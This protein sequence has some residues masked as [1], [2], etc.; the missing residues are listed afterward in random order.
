MK[1]LLIIVY[2]GTLCL[3]TNMHTQ[4]RTIQFEKEILPILQEKCWRCH[5]SRVKEPSAGLL[6]DTPK[7][8]MSGNEYGPVI[9]RMLPDESVLVERIEIKPGKRG[10][11]PPTGQGD[12][13]SPKQIALIR[14]WIKQG[15]KT[16][17]WQGYQKPKQAYQPKDQRYN[18]PLSHQQ[19]GKNDKNPGLKFI[20]MPE[21]NMRISHSLIRSKAQEIDQIIQKNRSKKGFK[22]PVK[23]ND[24]IFLRRAYLGIVG[25]IP[26]LNESVEFLASTQSNKRILLIDKLIASEGYASHWFHFWADLLKVDSTAVD[27]VAAVYYADWVK[28]ALASNMPYDQMV[29]ELITATGMPYQNGAT[30][31][32]ASDQNMKPDHMA[33]TVQAF[34]GIQIQCAQ[35]H[36]HPFDQWN[37]FEFQ[38]MVSYYGGVQYNIRGGNQLLVNRARDAGITDITQKQDRFFRQIGGRYRLSIWEPNFNRWHTLP[39]DYQYADA[40]PRQ[41]LAPAVMFGEQPHITSSPRAAF[42]EW[43]T[44]KENEFFADAIANRLWKQLMGVGLIEPIDEIKYHTDPS[45]PELLDTLSDMIVTFDFNLKDVLRVLYNTH[46]WQMETRTD[47]LP[48]DLYEY[49]Y[50]GRH[51]QR[52]TGEQMWDSIISLVVEDLDERKG[53]G[54]KYITDEFKQHLDDVYLMPI[55]KLVTT[56]TDESIDKIRQKIRNEQR[57]AY[58]VYMTDINGNRFKDWNGRPL[59][60]TKSYSYFNFSSWTHD[61]M[62]DPRWRGIERGL[63]RASELPSPAPGYHFVRQFGQ[64]DRQSI[65]TGSQDPNVTQALALLNGPIYYALDADNS[66][67]ASHLNKLE[68]NED[69]IHA[70]FRA[71]LTR[72]PTSDDIQIASQ[73]MESNYPK[74]AIRMILWA[75][76]NTREFMYIQ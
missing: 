21:N 30:G 62:T 55:E 33:N 15:A 18:S 70:L 23:A 65:G 71:I 20:P 2:T 19:Y 6:L 51:L 32:M 7:Q 31:W 42:A 57:D 22:K 69:R 40:K 4:A 60:E 68:K 27:Q 16:G 59:R 67:L 39:T 9:T 44:G 26:T 54:S 1:N 73:V 76:I 38:S 63:V 72:N 34:L 45:I 41:Q 75:L 52:M 8:L 29:Y 13:C 53:H 3:F 10:A 48:E 74:K 64:S 58:K 14:E 25:R 47:D 36:D 49:A 61:H 46:T 5:S 43:I 28:K 11:M 50:D 12:P 56:Y 24:R 17:D 37:Q 66:L 35:C